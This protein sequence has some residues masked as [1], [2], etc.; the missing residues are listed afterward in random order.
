MISSMPVVTAEPGAGL[1]VVFLA[2]RALFA[3]MFIMSGVAHLT[4]SQAMAGYAAMFHVPSPRLSVLLT[5]LMI[6]AGGVSV[7]LGVYVPIGCLL[8]VLF[9]VP[10]AFWM[11]RY[12]GV[13]DPMQAATQRAQFMKNITLAGAALLIY[14]FARVNPEAWIYSVG[15]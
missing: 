11:H 5:G 3:A 4:K 8:L 14:Y 1:A 2:G 12:W 9:L 6:L 10:V 13:S 7:L 15:R